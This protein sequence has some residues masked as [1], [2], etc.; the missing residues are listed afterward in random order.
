[1]QVNALSRIANNMAHSFPSVSSSQRL[2]PLAAH[3]APL[4]RAQS[5]G[6][7][8]A[9]LRRGRPDW[10]REWGAAKTGGPN[11]RRHE[12]RSGLIRASL[13]ANW[14]YAKE[15]HQLDAFFDMA[16]RVLDEK[17]FPVTSEREADLVIDRLY[18]RLH[19]N[20]MNIFYGRGSYN[21]MLG[22][23]AHGLEQH[24]ADYF[25]T[26]DS[27]ST[28]VQL[29]NETFDWLH[30]VVSYAMC[31]Y[32]DFSADQEKAVSGA[33]KLSLNPETLA[34][35]SAQLKSALAAID[36]YDPAVRQ[37][38]G[39]MELRMHLEK[40]SALVETVE[41]LTDSV[42]Q[43]FN[44]TYDVGP[45]SLENI[46]GDLKAIATAFLDSADTDLSEAPNDD[47][48]Q[49][50][51]TRA[52]EVTRG[53][54]D[55]VNR[56]DLQKFEETASKFLDLEREGGELLGIGS[57]YHKWFSQDA[58]RERFFDAI[59]SEHMAPTVESARFN[60]RQWDAPIRTNFKASKHTQRVQVVPSTLVRQVGYAVSN[61]AF[62]TG[63]E[64]EL[65]RAYE[66]LLKRPENS[67]NTLDQLQRAHAQLIHKVH[68]NPTNIY[69]G[70]RSAQIAREN[71]SFALETNQGAFKKAMQPGLSA[72]DFEHQARAW[73]A[74]V[75]NT[76]LQGY[77]ALTPLELRAVSDSVD[78]A[79]GE[80][81][82]NKFKDILESGLRGGLELYSGDVRLKGALARYDVHQLDSL[83]GKETQVIAFMQP[84]KEGVDALLADAETSVDDKQ[85]ALQALANRLAH[86]VTHASSQAPDLEVRKEQNK[87]LRFID[88]LL[89]LKA[90]KVHEPDADVIERF[91][92][93][94]TGLL[95]SA[96]TA[97]EMGLADWGKGAGSLQFQ[98]PGRKKH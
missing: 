91:E 7:E 42:A 10:S 39:P 15:T 94:L 33:I 71:V 46:K 87:L 75:L 29:K 47:L 14:N 12:V 66:R 11:H 84:V 45:A 49:L 68:N 43:I 8:N 23:L 35:D 40:Q 21:Q 17:S 52:M 65:M 56:P 32:M 96:D 83:R 93:V 54:S 82:S 34:L 67:I 37:D 13:Q 79:L 4:G 76:A 57:D 50:Q 53:F 95:D 64:A 9:E 48:R 88:P 25:N 6:P 26:L 38:E 77:L 72:K 55:L 18:T 30:K 5:G 90:E 16:N 61:Y 20:H 92:D 2:A 73:Q 97:K 19:N 69:I 3:Q 36:L 80:P 1:M 60:P 44:G 59:T 63:K 78:K 98:N 27:V 51:N 22:T 81:D 89:Q 74:K 70:S 62:G 86:R 58:S 24:E 31:E 28:K 85:L 41:V